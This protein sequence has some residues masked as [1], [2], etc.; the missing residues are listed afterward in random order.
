MPEIFVEDAEKM[1]HG[2]RRLLTNGRLEIGVFRIGDSFH[3]FLNVCPHQGGPVCQGKVMPRV[4][5]FLSADGTSLGLD[6]SKDEFHL[7]CPWHGYEYRF[8]TG[9]HPGASDV[10]IRRFETKVVEGKVYV[11]V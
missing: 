5:E 10:R 4:R 8:D 11:V 2:D 7:V 1:R 9:T 6:F 3:A